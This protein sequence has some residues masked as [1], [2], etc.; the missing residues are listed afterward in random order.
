MNASI[1]PRS[2]VDPARSF[3]L[4]A[5]AFDRARPAYPDEAVPWLLD[6]VDP[7]GERLHAVELG[8]GTGKLTEQLVTR[9]CEVTAVDRSGAMLARL[10]RREPT[11]RRT[12]GVAEQVPLAGRVAD[13]VVAAQSYH[14]FDGDRALPEAAR[15]LRPGGRFAVM[16]NRRDVRIPWVRRLGGLIGADARRE[17]P[18]DGFGS[19]VDESGMFET[20]ERTSFRFWQP[21][22][23][24]LLRD[25]VRSRPN[26]AMMSDPE[27][28]RVLRKVDELYEEY[29]RGADGMLLP[30]VT[31]ACRTTVLPWAVPLV[32]G[33]ADAAVR[34]TPTDGPMVWDDAGDHSLLIDFR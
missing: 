4:V 34:P 2:P 12:L 28:E 8:A 18:A 11:A 17:D 20:V 19:A 31:T 27:R 30:Y 1:S 10:A 26:V 24:D 16:W 3:D 15:V 5:D 22:S 7:S 29:G 6:G 23:R 13:L 21:T 32:E 25:L 9:G 14:W 33:P